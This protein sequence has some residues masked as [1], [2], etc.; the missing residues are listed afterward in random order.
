MAEVY[1]LVL[2]FNLQHEIFIRIFSNLF[3]I[4]LC[5]IRCPNIFISR[6]IM[7][8][9][10]LHSKFNWCIVYNAQC[11][12]FTIFAFC[13]L[14]SSGTCIQNKRL[15]IIG[16]F[17]SFFFSSF[18]KHKWDN[19]NLKCAIFYWKY[20][21]TSLVTH[22]RTYVLFRRRFS[23]HQFW[24]KRCL[25]LFSDSDRNRNLQSYIGPNKMQ[26]FFI[27]LHFLL[28]QTKMY[29]NLSRHAPFRAVDSTIRR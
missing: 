23:N 24:N 7:I 11:M 12:V 13:V 19:A 16:E 27:C 8:I 10:L 26:F 22:L 6:Y 2:T 28:L 25:P 14:H 1:Y 20:A 29:F 17:Q 4:Y 21:L 15:C 3:T 5:H 18:L 9:V